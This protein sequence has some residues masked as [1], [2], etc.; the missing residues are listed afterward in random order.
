MRQLR[1]QPVLV[2]GCGASGFAMA[3]WC[4]RQGA[5]V[6]VADTRDAPPQL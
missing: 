3:R 1:D 5:V 4:A 6:T 2:L